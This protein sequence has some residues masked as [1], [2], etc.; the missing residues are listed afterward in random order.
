MSEKD[1]NSLN[2]ILFKNESDPNSITAT[3]KPILVI[4]PGIGSNETEIYIQNAVRQAYD[5][6]Y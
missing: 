6:G 3:S 5:R 4:F 2:S 1:K